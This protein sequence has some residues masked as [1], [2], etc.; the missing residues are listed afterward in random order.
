MY[1]QWNAFM[2]L[3]EQSA[4]V[5]AILSVLVVTTSL[6]VLYYKRKYTLM[7]RD[8]RIR[9]QQLEQNLRERLMSIDSILDHY[10]EPV[11]Y[12]NSKGEYD[13]CNRE[14]EKLWG[15]SRNN[16]M[17]STPESLFPQESD[18]IRKLDSMV[19]TRSKPLVKE[20][21][22]TDRDGET[23]TYELSFHQMDDPVSGGK[24]VLMY[25]KDISHYRDQLDI[26]NDL[27]VT[28]REDLQL[29]SDYYADFLKTGLPPLNRIIEDSDTLL[30]NDNDRKETRKKLERITSSGQEMNST[31]R[32][33][34]F[35]AFPDKISA[36]YEGTHEQPLNETRSLEDWQN[37]LVLRVGSFHRDHGFASFVL[38][39]GDVPESLHTRFPLLNELLERL[40]ENA[41]GHS[42][43]GVYLI[44][45][46][47]RVESQFF[48]MN[49]TV[50]N[51][52]PAIDAARRE[53]IFKPF[54]RIIAGGTGPGLGLTVAR[55]LAE[56]MGG[57]LSC[58]PTCIDGAR[59]LLSLPPIKGEGTVISGYRLGG[60]PGRN[61]GAILIADNDKL[62]RK[63]LVSHL[64]LAGYRVD[65][66]EDGEAVLSLMKE[67]EYFLV[68]VDDQ[69]PLI[70]GVE[71]QKQWKRGDYPGVRK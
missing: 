69:T 2:S 18:E 37:Q 47:H 45:K 3:F 9:H 43:G 14:L 55:S 8:E 16:I 63:K 28:V 70:S 30:H 27:Y 36:L 32:N 35:L 57:S 58:D 19:R 48:T 11:V 49:I 71:I 50:R 51:I 68:L 59:F 21:K 40:I 17:G 33:L 24:G 44:L 46:V 7:I 66:A 54:T 31:I 64:R 29:R 1:K 53:D 52:G 26:L 25:F 22:F 12:K 42:Q 34:S 65:Q 56:K 67:K 6:I 23:R 4:L 10:P 61:T 62:F 5:L 13:W 38:L 20:R 15:L 41:E 39:L 60:Q